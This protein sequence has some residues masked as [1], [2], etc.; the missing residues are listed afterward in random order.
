LSNHGW[1]P[2]SDNGYGACIW[3]TTN[4]LNTLDQAAK[5]KDLN[6]STDSSVRYDNQYSWWRGCFAR[7]CKSNSPATTAAIVASLTGTLLLRK[8]SN[9]ST[10]ISGK[11][12]WL[13]QFLKL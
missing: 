10:D 9:A 7:R 12:V 4:T 11:H 6:V 2:S 5:T 1:Q 3:L 8:Y 13:M